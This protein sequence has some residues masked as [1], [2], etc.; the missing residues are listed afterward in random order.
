[1]ELSTFDPDSFQSAVVARCAVDHTR[2]YSCIFHEGYLVATT[3]E[4][5]VVV[6]SVRRHLVGYGD[7]SGRKR[8]HRRT[9]HPPHPVPRP[10]PYS[11]H[12]SVT[13]IHTM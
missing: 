11:F 4:G 10:W 13:I 3:S 12:A 8:A 7:V 1:M 5:R 2:V 6:W 9:T